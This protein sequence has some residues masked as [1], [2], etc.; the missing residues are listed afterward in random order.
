MISSY[1]MKQPAWGRLMLS[2]LLIGLAS[3]LHAQQCVVQ[4]SGGAALQK[5]ANAN[6]SKASAIF[7]NYFSKNINFR[8]FPGQNI[9]PTTPKEIRVRAVVVQNT[10]LSTPQY[11]N[12]PTDIAEINALLQ[13]WV[14]PAWIPSPYGGLGNILAPTKPNPS[15]CTNCHIADSKFRVKLVGIDFVTYDG[16]DYHTFLSTN[17]GTQKNDSILN[18]LLIEH[19]LNGTAATS[20]I[21]GWTSGG[22]NFGLSDAFQAGVGYIALSGPKI[23]SWGAYAT[24]IHELGHMFGLWHLYDY[25]AGQSECERVGTG[26]S[27][28]LSDIF[29]SGLCVINSPWACDP[30]T[31]LAPINAN[32]CSDNFMGRG[33]RYLSPMQ[34]GR[35][36]RSAYLGSMS[37]YI[38]PTQ[39]HNA[40]PWQVS[41][42]QV[43]DFGIRMYQDIIV[44]AGK[45][46]TITCEVQMPPDGRITVEKGAKLVLDGGTITSYH[47]K[48]GWH[49]IQL[50]GDKSAPPYPANQGSFEM[51]NNATIEN[52]Y[53]AV[54]DFTDDMLQGGGIINV[55][56]SI[57]RDCSRAIE[58]N[59][60]PSFPRGSSCT[61]SN[62]QFLTENPQAPTNINRDNF[63]MVSS[64]NERGVLITKCTFQNKIP[65]TTPYFDISQRNRAIYSVDAGFRIQNCSFKG[66]KE[67]ININ[68]Y[69]N[70]PLRNVKIMNCTFDSVASGIIFAD[71][72]SYAQ[73]NTFDNLLNYVYT[74]GMQTYLHE[75]QAIYADRTGGLTLTRNTILN[76]GNNPNMRGITINHTNNTGGRVIDNVINNA[77]L[78][79]T[80]QQDNQALDLLCNRFVGG[81]YNFLINPQSTWG[82]LKNQGNGCGSTQ[83]RA[84]NGFSGPVVK[85]IAS[86]TANPWTY[87]YWASPAQT[88]V[89]VSGTFT[90]T[91]CLGV[92]P[93]D[94]NSM[95]NLP[96]NVESNIDRIL[97]EA[98]HTWI[99]EIGPGPMQT[100][101]AAEFAGIINH[102]NE[103]G[104]IE[105]MV[106]FLEAVD[107]IEA[108]KLLLPLYLEQENY[109]AF[110]KLL[111]NL[112]LPD[113]EITA[114]HDYY[115]LL[116]T[117][118]EE[119]RSIKM[120]TEEELS[121][122]REIAAGTLDISDRAKSLLDFG[123]NEPWHHY[124]EQ[125]PSELSGGIYGTKV[126]T[127][128]KLSDAVPNP[129]ERYTTV[130]VVLSQEDAAHA[131][132]LVHDMMGKLVRT[133]TLKEAGNHNL[134]ID[135]DGLPAGL[136]IYT[137]QVNGK[138]V[139]S[140]RLAVTK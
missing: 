47:A 100:Q 108:K 53:D 35:M 126:A 8:P 6:C 117:L 118:K 40:T 28:W 104:S 131:L 74:S 102:Y 37:R 2:L 91:G 101:M 12:N 94:P 38:Y 11:A 116:R 140:K 69:S 107:H 63:P 137:L 5:G 58:L 115:S 31:D 54:Q 46:L 119:N 67:A 109:S 111:A 110:D 33:N 99:M 133:Y 129:A 71:N 76:S 65:M 16:Q 15:T 68:T 136:Y 125:M 30:T 72:F 20:G 121:M 19:E 96:G 42:D 41:S 1:L 75:G 39:A 88:P 13:D 10:L 36:H 82:A 128:S 34:L 113:E 98:F 52:A 135:L 80:T 32:S 95:C 3:H 132:L 77:R 23:N 92:D 79:I 21:N 14:N 105:E 83:Y 139:Q 4:P 127:Q 106:A 24:F 97:D 89:Y 25:N 138:M 81:D 18:V 90:R 134:R 112:R 44:K 114:Y 93:I 9:Q 70:S 57:F 45:T 122:V 64:Y 43:W 123:Y 56:N 62:V 55:N 124:Q 59:D 7:T 84:G 17:Y 120:L 103:T 78:G 51:K 60:Y 73:G 48:T 49:G 86:Y 87:Y 27:D 61:L 130:K 50:Y 29:P 26:S 66:Y 22:N 85:H